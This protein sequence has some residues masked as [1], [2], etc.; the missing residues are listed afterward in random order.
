MA[1]RIA[2][3][4]LVL[5]LAIL[6]PKIYEHGQSMWFLLHDNAP[7]RMVKINNFGSYEIKFAD[8]VRSC[9]DA[10][11]VES[12]G[13]AIF[14]CDAGRERW[15]TVMGIFL[16][17]N[18]TGAE[19]YAYDYKTATA[20]DSESLNRLKIVDYEYGEDFHTLGMAYNE[21]TST[22]F[23]VNHREEQMAVEMFKLDLASFTA[24]HLGSIQHPL[25][26][27]PNSIAVINDHELYITNDHYF[28]I[29][30]HPFLAVAET[31]L[32]PPLASVVHVD[33]SPLLENTGNSVSASIV[34]RL[35]FANGI[36]ILN[37]TTVAVASTSTAAVYLYRVDGAGNSPPTWTYASQIRLPFLVDNLK[38]SRDGALFAAGHPNPAALARFAHSRH[39]CNEA[40]ALEAADASMRNFCDTYRAGSWVARWTEAGGVEHLYADVEFPTS[41]TA[42]FDAE[43][44]TGIVSGLYAKG[45]LVWRD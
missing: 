14:S 27:T 26:H 42:A 45:I 11:L 34:A 12:E 2:L 41:C 21:A 1:L 25:L 40:G 23:V 17:G 39:I 19:L 30:K 33:I 3:S 28:S 36:A 5:A 13:L 10:L 8:K 6:S 31:Y 7:E 43:R 44:R 32:H 18:N 4:V 20:P 35:P 22:L 38:R 24:K 15:N 37:E 9:E 16:P 29:R